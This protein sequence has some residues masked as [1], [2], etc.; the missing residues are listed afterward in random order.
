MSTSKFGLRLLEERARLGISQKHLRE[1]T[2]V[3]KNTQ[4]NYESGKTSPDAD[5][6]QKLDSL[7]FDVQY[8][9][10]G[11]RGSKLTEEHQQLL[12]LWES[13]PEVIRN[14]ACAVLLS[15]RPA[16]DDQSTG[17]SA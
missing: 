14:A 11:Q 7:G 15:H 6:L 3:G 4:L 8:L 5:Y 10:T 2:G 1:L 13:A 16:A 9:V 12:S 17:E